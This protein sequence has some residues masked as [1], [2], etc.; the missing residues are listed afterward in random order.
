MKPIQIFSSLMSLCPERPGLPGYMRE[1]ITFEKAQAPALISK[2]MAHSW[3]DA[4]SHES[5]E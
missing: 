5:S 3:Q 2:L 1:S 4:K